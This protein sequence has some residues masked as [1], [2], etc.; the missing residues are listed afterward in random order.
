MSPGLPW[1]SL[2]ALVL[3]LAGLAAWT[4][5]VRGKDAGAAVA[6]WF[7][8]HLLLAATG[9]LASPLAP[10]ALAWVALF[11][12]RAPPRAVSP[13]V[14]LAA[15]AGIAAH[16]ALL[17]APEGAALL[18][19]MLLLGVG[20]GLAAL[21]AGRGMGV[22]PPAVAAGP[23]AERPR[24]AGGEVSAAEAVESALAT[25]MRA[26]DA[27]EAALW[28]AEGEDDTRTA[29]LLA[30]VAAPEV[31]VPESPVA[32][33]GHP[34]GWAIDERLPQRIERG[35]RALP[36]PWAAEMLL[37]PVETP[38]GV[39]VLA[40]SYPGVVPPGAEPAAVR[41]AHDLSTLL[42]L[43]RTRSA[44]RRAEAGMRAI[45]EAVRTLPGELELDRFAAQLA[46][47]VLQG[48]G[49]AGAAVAMATD[50]A[51]RGKVL[52]TS[53]ELSPLDA[54]GFGEADSRLALAVKHGVE[55]SH[56]DLRRERERL[57]LLTPSE[58][59]ETAPRSL[60]ILPLMLEGRAMGAVAAWHTEP[61]R[62][63]EREMEIVRL[64]CS[65]APLP[66]RSARRFEAL[67]Q[68]ASTD[69]LTGLPNRGAFDA[70]LA[71]LSG[72]YDRYARPFALLTLDVDFFKKFNDTWGH[73]AGDRV[74]KHVADILR[75][76][77]RDVDLPAR[78]GGEE[79]VVLLPETTVRQAAEAA[80]RIRR[81]LEVRAVNWNGRS[82]LVTASFG[83][84]SVPDCATHPGELAGLADAALYRAKESGRN[85][86]YAA[87]RLEKALP[88]L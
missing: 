25:V 69:P 11:S 41:A 33:A 61:A 4:G 47:A 24:R 18:R 84:A 37:V 83:V 76:A 81:M 40:L 88:E 22:R 66:M 63:G 39:R 7:P 20:A 29:A 58:R 45:A 10:L 54:E 80:E 46:A 42:G 59:W 64:L 72:F 49:A 31:P 48:T 55:L 30:R 60:V 43:L 36:S 62:F 15:L 68:R 77:V 79:F 1:W 87:P 67:D 12:R 5:R 78:I 19:W 6:L 51:G 26:T 65:I 32:L 52:H 74:L 28:R 13:A 57:P 17:G 86:V 75:K 44:V 71:A 38:E 53:G 70:R 2:A 23:G 27:H 82:L 35:K 56:A 14:G 9:H 50:D 34:F 3:L 85:R 8:L 73:E 21:V 16:W